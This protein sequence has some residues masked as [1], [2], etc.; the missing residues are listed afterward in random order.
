M[1]EQT[2][3]EQLP[4]D[5]DTALAVCGIAAR[6]EATYF[7][8]PDRR[9]GVCSRASRVVAC[10]RVSGGKRLSMRLLSTVA[11]RHMCHNE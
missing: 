10:P 7:R 2:T 6:D 4:E 3:A 5:V 11:T 8:M 1:A 9:R